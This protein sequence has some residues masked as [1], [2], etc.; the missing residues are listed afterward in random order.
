[1]KQPQQNSSAATIAF[2]AMFITFNVVIARLVIIPVPWTHGNVNLCDSGIFIAAF[3]YGRKSG[4]IVG[5]LSGFLLDMISGYSQYLLFS[6]I[7]HG[8][9][10]WIAGVIGKHDTGPSQ[11]AAV[12][13][14][15][16]IT[17][18]GYYLADTI[19]YGNWAGLAGIVP[20]I[21]Q[22][23]VNAALA[24]ILKSFIQ[25]HFSRKGSL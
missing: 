5:S 6:F 12:L 11:I 15:G 19:L 22:I 14:A 2:L 24:I 25:K 10:G 4:A 13:V 17:V 21:I 3:I 18:G 9:E 23:V 1:M 20:N 7:I 16:L 8:L